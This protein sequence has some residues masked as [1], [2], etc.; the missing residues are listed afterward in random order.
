VS[1]TEPVCDNVSLSAVYFLPSCLI[2][3][4]TVSGWCNA[5]HGM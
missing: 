1:A 3:W 4:E 2:T 5:M